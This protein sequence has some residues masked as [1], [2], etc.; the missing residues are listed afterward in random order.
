MFQRTRIRLT[1]LNSLVFIILIGVLAAVIY[2]YAGSRLYRDVNNDLLE[3]AERLAGTGQQRSII[4]PDGLPR[5]PRDPRIALLIW[6]EKNELITLNGDGTVFSDNESKFRPNELEMLR[7][8]EAEGFHFRTIAIKAYHPNFGVITVQ[9]ARNI[10]S[11]KEMLQTLL[12]ILVIGSG[13]GCLC[14]V[15]AGFFLAG[16][17]L[18][19]IKK[20]W[21]KQQQFVSDASHELRTPLAVIQTKTD[22]LWRSPTSTIQDKAIDISVIS[23]EGRRLSKLVSNLLTLARSDSDQLEMEKKEFLLSHLLMELIEHYSEIALY[24][25]KELLLDAPYPVSLI[26]DKERIHQLMV[27]LIDNAMKYTKEGG[28]III[29]CSQTSH[30]VLIKVQDNGIG[31]EEE[32]MPKIFDRFFQVD[33]SRTEEAGAGLGLAIAKWIIDKHYGKVKVHSKV[34]VGTSFEIIF[35]KNQRI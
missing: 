34:G 21:Q 16:R 10:T 8:T 25:E 20:A 22:L 11:E 4:Q 13:I 23:K 30:S 27:I 32:N 1:I 15:G 35:P 14:A 24:Q 28:K 3:A 7:D 5:G 18:V 9:F 17:A 31:I 6:N 26:G 12:L 19:P 33:K 2:S 29:S